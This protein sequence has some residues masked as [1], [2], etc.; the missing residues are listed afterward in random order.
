MDYC[1]ADTVF[2]E[3]VF[4]MPPNPRKYVLDPRLYNLVKYTVVML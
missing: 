3:I 1:L 4:K 2:G